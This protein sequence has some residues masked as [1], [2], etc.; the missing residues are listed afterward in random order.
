MA[1][2]PG[3]LEA[4]PL[5]LR[6]AA[7]AQEPGRTLGRQAG[8]VT[9]VTGSLP[10]ALSPLSPDAFQAM[11]A[12]MAWSAGITP[13]GPYGHGLVAARPPPPRLVAPRPPPSKRECT[14]LR[15]TL[16]VPET[17]RLSLAEGSRVLQALWKN[18]IQEDVERI[19]ARKL[20]K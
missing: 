16:V 19:V 11:L 20:S 6:L 5:W 3:S 1:P 13:T 9:Y 7:G 18:S 2:L 10:G 12:G 4:P 14:A 15:P 8:G 17:R